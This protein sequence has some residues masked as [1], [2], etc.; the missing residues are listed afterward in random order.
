MLAIEVEFLLGRAVATHWSRRDRAEWP[1]HPQRLFSALVATHFEL[2]LGPRSEAALKWLEQ[3][4]P[5][6]VRV[7]ATPA[8]RAPISHWVPVNDETAKAEKGRVDF[9]HILE[10]RNRQERF[11]PAVIPEDPVVTFQWPN[12][13]GIDQHRE[14]LALL[15]EGLSYLGHSASP[16]RGCL[17]DLPVEPTLI[18]SVAGEYS[19]RVPGPGRFERLRHIHELRIEEESVQP[20]LGRVQSYAARDQVPGT[21]FSPEAF[22][23]AFD[24]G[25]KLSL[26]STMPLMQ[27]LRAAVLSRLGQ[28][29]PE[30]IAGHEVDGKPSTDTHAAFVPLP[31]VGS[32]YADGSLK[33]AAIVLPRYVDVSVRQRLRRALLSSWQLQLGPLGSIE[34]RLHEPAAA[35]PFSLRF[36]TYAGPSRQWASVTPVFLDRHPKRGKL[37]AEQ[38]ISDS[39][40]RVG[41]PRPTDVRLG[42]ASGLNGVPLAGGFRGLSKQTNNRVRH[43]VVL[44]FDRL[45]RG[46]LLLG[47]GRFIGLGIFLPI[48]AVEA[49]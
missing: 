42:H 3:L 12:A 5:P 36:S 21:V 13:T 44:Q 11:F 10:R 40:E 41:L 39:C 38:I 24:S 16:V 9:R 35:G 23:L 20:P 2:D 1:P 17:R 4:Q 27:H 33:G 49:P 18:P 48:E 31:F 6:Q 26:D 32:R 15:V 8:Y 22:V 7:D 19:L 29:V 45:V 30:V 47:A 34:V 37:T 14:A 28:A 25:P 43:H 46:P